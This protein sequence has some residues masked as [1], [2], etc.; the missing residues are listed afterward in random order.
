MVKKSKSMF[1]KVFGIFF[2]KEAF[3]AGVYSY[4]YNKVT[5]QRRAIQVIKGYSALDTLWLSSGE[6][7]DWYDISF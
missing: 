5:K 2:W 7:G 6:T 1:I 4:Q 3:Q